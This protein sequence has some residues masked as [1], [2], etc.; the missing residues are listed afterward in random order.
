MANAATLSGVA[1]TRYSWSSS[2][3]IGVLLD[4]DA[5]VEWVGIVED[6]IGA[7]LRWSR[8]AV[9]SSYADQSYSPFFRSILAPA[10]IHANELE[11]GSGDHVEVLIMATREMDI[12]SDAGWENA[13]RESRQRESEAGRM[14]GVAT[15]A[16]TQAVVQF[17]ADSS[18]TF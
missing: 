12:N 11:A 7:Q 18:A 15:V 10:E 8:W 9:S 1:E 14:Q 3:V 4:D 6:V 5:L 2:P 17:A 16:P 13:R